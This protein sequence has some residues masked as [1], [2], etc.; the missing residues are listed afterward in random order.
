MPK[1]RPLKT[2]GFSKSALLAGS[3]EGI[4]LLMT[5][6]VLTILTVIVL[7]FSYMTR[8]EL[9]ASLTFRH[10]AEKKLLAESGI[11]RGIMEVFYR[12]QN[13][14]SEGNDAWKMDG[15]P[16]RVEAEDGYIII[17]LTDESGKVDI[18][19]TPEVI[20]RNL[21][22][23]LGVKL[24]DIDIIADSIMDWKDADDL[25]R[26][27]GAENEYYMSLPNPY[28]SKNAN[29]ETL[30]E[31]LLIRGVTPEILYG[32]GG[33]KGIIDFLT[34]SSKTGKINVSIAPKEVLLAIPGMS[35]EIADAIFAQREAGLYSGI[36]GLMG[37]AYSA[38]APFIVIAGPSASGPATVSITAAG[39]K[40]TE[41]GGYAIRAVVSIEG[42]NQVK[43]LYYK[44]P[45]ENNHVSD[46]AN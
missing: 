16:E 1:D 11:E 10:E 44:S 17:S 31:L 18:N 30:E 27:H 20:L 26:L 43:Y 32:N 41:K 33:K 42:N 28:K 36:Q 7:S 39:Y 34:V 6:W 2:I 45:A 35:T 24:E 12:M 46:S 23:N 37:Q 15:T 40:G 29:I 9:S 21:L 13:L 8:T 5:I 14:S 38:M 22:G 25:H 3:E 19:T 4:A